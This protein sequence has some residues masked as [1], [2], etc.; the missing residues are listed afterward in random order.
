MSYLNQITPN[1]TFIT[2]L[3][4]ARGLK[5]VNERITPAYFARRLRVVIIYVKLFVFMHCLCVVDSP[6]V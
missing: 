6:L 3:F 4:L 1:I 2:A 5:Q